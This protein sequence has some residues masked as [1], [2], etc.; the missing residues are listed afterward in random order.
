MWEIDE[1][2]VEINAERF[3]I[4]DPDADAV[5]YE[6]D[7]PKIFLAKDGDGGLVLV[8]W[9]DEDDET[10]RYVIAPTSDR[11]VE[12]LRKGE[13]SVYDALNQPRC[14]IY[15]IGRQGGPP[16][17]RLVDFEDVPKD[18]LPSR[19]TMLWPSLEPMLTLRAMG[20]DIVPGRIP[21]S[22]IRACVEGVQRSLKILSEYVLGRDA[23]QPGRP[24]DLVRRL[25]DL[26]TQRVAFASFE[27]SYR[28]P[29]EPADLF[30]PLGEKSREAETLEEVGSLLTKGL[31]WLSTSAAE[32]G[33]YRPDDPEESAAVLRALKEITPSS[34]GA[35][36][37]LEIKGR[38]INFGRTSIE[39]KRDARLRVNEAIRARELE[40]ELVDLEGRVGRADVDQLSFDLRDIGHPPAS[41]RFVFDEELLEDVLQAL[42]DGTRVRVAG[43]LHPKSPGRSL[44]FALA[45]SSAKT[46]APGGAAS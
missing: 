41:Q 8:Y 1:K 21:A 7:G 32:A 20:A 30:S 15:D 14:W 33:L 24:D 39:L 5:L 19:G 6:F 36:R 45:I 38:L 4:A 35:I 27:I 9:S 28:M 43:L 13:T 16:R 11:I 44:A 3:A 2:A 26:P 10:T 40:P 34:Q 18:A 12:S 29:L 46:T 25:I 22:V 37:R 42:N 17:C 23:G 31:K